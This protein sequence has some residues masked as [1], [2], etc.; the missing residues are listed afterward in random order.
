MPAWP[1]IQ[2]TYQ[3]GDVAPVTNAETAILTTGPISTPGAGSVVN[4]WAA[5][6]MVAGAGTT[7]VV[8]R[9]RRGTGVAGAIVGEAAT[10]TLAATAL[11]ALSMAVADP[12][13]DAAGQ[14]YTLTVQQTGGTGNGNVTQA[15]VTLQTV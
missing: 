14:V 8:L 15:S 9:I 6:A 1:K 10:A 11:G 12:L 5:L 3:S 2:S 4:I 7:A 13:G